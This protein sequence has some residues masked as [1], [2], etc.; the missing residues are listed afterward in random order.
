MKFIER[1]RTSQE[2]RKSNQR[3]GTK[4]AFD[5]WDKGERWS[6]SSIVKPTLDIELTQSCNYGSYG[7][8]GNNSHGNHGN[9]SYGNHGNNSHSN[10]GNS[11]HGKSREGAGVIIAGKAGFPLERES[12]RPSYKVSPGP[13]R[14]QW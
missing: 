1:L 13:T 3:R 10:H 12:R 9:S 7:N 5:F 11:S 8:H 6:T 2:E 14:Y 4:N